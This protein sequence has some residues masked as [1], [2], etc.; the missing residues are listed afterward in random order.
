MPSGVCYDQIVLSCELNAIGSIDIDLSVGAHAKIPKDCLILDLQYL[1]LQF[2]DT[3]II[4]PC[5][6]VINPE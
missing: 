1:L 2:G 4:S 3:C 5:L 6:Y